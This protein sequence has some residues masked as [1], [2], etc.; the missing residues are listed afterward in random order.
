MVKRKM[1]AWLLALVLL[2]SLV[3]AEVCLAVNE[4]VL[5][6]RNGVVRVVNIV[7]EE[8]GLLSTGTGF[9][10]GAPGEPVH[11]F[12]TNHHV[13]DGRTSDYVY[14]VMND[15]SDEDGIY[16][17]QVVYES[18]AP[19]LAILYSETPVTE[20]TPLPLLSAEYLEVTQE[21]YA[22]GFPGVSDNQSDDPN[23]PSSIEDITVTRGTVTR[24]EMVNDGVY[25]VQIDAVV[26]NGNSGGPLVTENGCV[27]GINTFIA[28][29]SDDHTRADGT[30]YSQYIDY[31]MALL[32]ANDLPYIQGEAPD[33]SGGGGQTDPPATEAP[34][35]EP[36]TEA[37][38]AESPEQEETREEETED[39][40]E[41]PAPSRE[42]DEDSQLG[43]VVAIAAAVAVVAVVAVLLLKKRSSRGGAGNPGG[44]GGQPGPVP[45]PGGQ[46]GGF[47][48][49]RQEAA[50]WAIG[51]TGVS[52]PL[53]GQ[54][55]E[56]QD[57]V[58]VG[59]DP[60]R[61]QLIF[62]EGTPGVSS[63]HCE[64]RFQGGR[65]YLTD[66]GSTYGTF[67]NGMQVPRNQPVALNA[68][69]RFYLGDPGNAFQVG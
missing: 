41:E 44:Y 55:I 37:P 39:P 31:V 45:G 34:T 56:V 20:R 40:E 62:P 15:L 63:L 29:N 49:G 24:Q 38:T 43:V 47:G 53:A 9:A 17:V 11:Y 57:V 68:G 13:V 61:C 48:P 64:L 8:E 51:I 10:V 28:L 5:D 21:V 66:L 23:L 26:N 52:G 33:G 69:D 14:L 1:A 16:P 60:S 58:R 25:C 19:D 7:D 36:A 35:E 6:A 3:P 46:P 59:R 54:R 65:L 32:D 18:E 50:A 42:R 12:V 22:L 2:A 30:N 4:D 27:V 67:C